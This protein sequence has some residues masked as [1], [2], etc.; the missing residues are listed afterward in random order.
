MVW[1]FLDNKKT[2][3]SVIYIR[4]YNDLVPKLLTTKLGTV[5]ATL[6]S[7]A[8]DMFKT[9]KHELIKEIKHICHTH[10]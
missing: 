8:E 10:M 2:I 4:S 3:F 7:L 9:Y 6:V 5:E 1:L